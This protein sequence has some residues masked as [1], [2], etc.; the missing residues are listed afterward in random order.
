MTTTVE[1]ELQ[2][3]LSQLN[4]AEKQSILQLIRTFVQDRQQEEEQI[5]IERYNKELEEAEAEFE[6]GEYITHEEMLKQMKQW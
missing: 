5:S 6:R 2:Q 4:D 3:Y 1:Q